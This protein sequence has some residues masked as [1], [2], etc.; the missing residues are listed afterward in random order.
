MNVLS[1]DADPLMITTTYLHTTHKPV[2]LSGIIIGVVPRAST[3][4]LVS[5]I[6]LYNCPGD[7]LIELSR[8]KH[9]EQASPHPGIE[10]N[11]AHHS[12]SLF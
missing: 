6:D 1:Y 3:H 5:I 4:Y 12:F 8:T 11:R 9:N 7:E 2:S 10:K